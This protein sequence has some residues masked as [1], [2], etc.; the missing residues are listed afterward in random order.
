MWRK[1]GSDFGEMLTNLKTAQR[2]R[3]KP[4]G[5]QTETEA[6]LSPLGVGQED[7]VPE[8]LQIATFF[9]DSFNVL[10]RFPEE[11]YQQSEETAEQLYE[12]IYEGHKV[13]SACPRGFK[14]FPKCS[15]VLPYALC[16][17]SLTSSF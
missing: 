9:Y 11:Q 8:R 3:P 7:A 1:C 15:K 17:D 14:A 16:R 6:R 4:G 13:G 10:R 12:N 2:T 5:A